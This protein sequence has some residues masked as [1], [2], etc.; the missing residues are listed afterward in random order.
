MVGEAVKVA[1]VEFQARSAPFSRLNTALEIA[2]RVQCQGQLPGVC[3][4]IGAGGIPESELVHPGQG[5]D[6]LSESAEKGIQL[7]WPAV[8]LTAVNSGDFEEKVLPADGCEVED[9]GVQCLPFGKTFAF[10]TPGRGVDFGVEEQPP[11]LLAD[12][13]GH[14]RVLQDGER[15]VEWPRFVEKRPPQEDPLVAVGAFPAVQLGF[16]F[17]VIV[18]MGAVVAS[19]DKAQGEV[20]RQTVVS[21]FS[22]C[23][24]NGIEA[25]ADGVAVGEGGVGV[26]EQ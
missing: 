18:P 10:Q 15:F 24:V 6:L 4:H 11:A 13:F 12:S 17:I 7:Q 20:P 21:G 19:A 2:A 23:R 8:V 16:A 25:V 14:P 22:H 3:T 26:E 9:D 5:F 1:V